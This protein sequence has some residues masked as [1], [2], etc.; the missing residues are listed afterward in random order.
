MNYDAPVVTGVGNF[1]GGNAV[2]I[3]T[4]D[5]SVAGQTVAAP[6][7][8]AAPPPDKPTVSKGFKG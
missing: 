3:V 2:G 4:P 8:P 6:S 7:M 5:Q 1:P